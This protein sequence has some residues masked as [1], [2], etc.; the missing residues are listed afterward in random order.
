[1]ATGLTAFLKRCQGQVDEYLEQL[2]PEGDT[3]LH[4]AM[5]Y[6]L[7]NGGKRIRPALCY[8]AAELIG[9]PS[10]LTHRAACAVEMIHA[11]SLIHDDLP[12]MDNDDLRRGKPTCH[13]AFGEATAILAGDGLQ[14]LAFNV[15]SNGT[16]DPGLQLSML[17]CLSRASGPSGMVGGQA[18]D[19]AAVNRHLEL[20]NLEA[21]HRAKTG[22]L[23]DASIELGA[24]STGSATAPQLSAL[25]DYSRSI[26][27][28]FQVRDDI[29]DVESG[30]E[31]LGKRQGAD[32]ALNKPT[33][34][35]L[36]GLA[37]AKAKLDELHEQSLQALEIFG[38]R[39]GCLTE[40]AHFIVSRDH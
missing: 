5:R 13:I 23:I 25:R 33:Y 21:M 4:R 11:Y 24:L 1:M 40:I 9:T 18:L 6:S 39:A 12:S 17:A 30:T 20:S 26:G 2:L 27:L 3:S 10:L 7:F 8:A 34:T 15:L 19:L 16:F 37:G 29:L 38:S 36:L 22:A 31:V 28:A 32:N 35:S 14:A